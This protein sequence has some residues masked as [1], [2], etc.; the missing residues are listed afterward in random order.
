MRYETN[1]LPQLVNDHFCQIQKEFSRTFH[2]D[3]YHSSTS[4]SLWS[5][6]PEQK[7]Y[8][9]DLAESKR[10]KSVSIICKL[11]YFQNQN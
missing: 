8:P 11:K 7:S 6:R 3:P 9:Y 4:V 2:I 5:S 10:I 1:V